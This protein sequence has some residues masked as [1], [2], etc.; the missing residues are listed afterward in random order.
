MGVKKRRA[1][2]VGD[3]WVNRVQCDTCK[4]IITSVN[5]H[6]YVT[7]SCG[8]IAVDGGSWYLRR[9]GDGGYTEMSEQYT[10]LPKD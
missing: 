5:R 8:G 2:D 9:I 3:I 6:N 10:Y 7:C 1:L 4:D